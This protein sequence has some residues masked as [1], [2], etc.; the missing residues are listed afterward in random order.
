[1]GLA[2]ALNQEQ[3][4]RRQPPLLPPQLSI[5]TNLNLKLS[6]GQ[7]GKE[8]GEQQAA[9]NTTTLLSVEGGAFTVGGGTRAAPLRWLVV[10]GLPAAPLLEALASVPGLPEDVAAAV[11]AGRAEYHVT[12]WHAEDP[13]LGQDLDLRWGLCMNLV[14]VIAP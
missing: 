5:S 9:A 14:S 2:S 8:G 11:A 12:L 3:C 6:T 7:G 1:M 13:D 4:L 10:A